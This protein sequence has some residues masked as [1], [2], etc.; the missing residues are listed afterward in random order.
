MWAAVNSRSRLQIC[1]DVLRA[2]HVGTK[3]DGTLRLYHIERASGLTHPRLKRYLVMLRNLGFVEDP[4]RVTP[5][6]YVFLEEVASK[7]IP[8]MRKYGF[9][10]TRV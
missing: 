6:G 2:I 9:W 7:V 3:N 5:L 4:P 8:I 10:Q 1:V